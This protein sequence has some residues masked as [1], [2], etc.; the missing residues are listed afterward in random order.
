MKLRVAVVTESFLPSINGVTNS[1]IRVLESLKRDGH[2]ALILAPTTPAKEFLGFKVIEINRF[3]FKEF[4]VALPHLNL[5][6]ILEDFAPDVIHVAAPFAFGRQAIE[7]AKRMNVP[8][9]AI[10]QTDIAGYA[11]RYGVPFIRPT[12]DRV[13][14]AIHRR[15]TV[16]LAPT[17]E[18]AEYLRKIG[19]KNVG[20]WGRGVDLETYNPLR[21]D[22][23]EIKALRAQIADPDEIVIG[24]VGRL[25][26]EKQ[27]ER[28]AELFDIPNTRFLIVGDGPER[29]NLELLFK[30]QKVTFAGKLGGEQLA[31]AYAQMDIFV[32]CGTEETFGQTIQ[33]AQASGLPV[34]APAS[35]GPKFLIESGQSGFLVDHAKAGSYRDRVLQLIND[36]DLRFQMGL[37]ARNAVLGKS[38]AQN[39]AK[40]FEHYSFAMT[41]NQ[42]GRELELAR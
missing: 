14:G 19:A 16:N 37:G 1:V 6:G 33:E 15:A 11:Q 5:Q 35:G 4:P 10:Y 20:I 31:N 28:F 39:N 26:A 8:S 30:G 9:V 38:W 7:V 2:E 42:N 41:T 27:V 32:H 36:F 13:I 3:Y 23:A 21:K 18:G 22:T 17:T 34:V 24:F 25:A 40:L 29:E 12:I